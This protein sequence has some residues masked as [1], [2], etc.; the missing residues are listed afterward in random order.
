MR[1]CK[2]I[3]RLFRTWIFVPLVIV[4]FQ[5]V[6]LS[7]TVRTFFVAPTTKMV[8]TFGAAAVKGG[9]VSGYRGIEV[10]A[11][12]FQKFKSIAPPN[13]LK[14]YQNL[15]SGNALRQHL[16]KVMKISGG[17]VDVDIILLDD[18]T[19][20]G[21]NSGIFVAY[22]YG[23]KKISWPAASVGPEAGGRYRGLVRLSEESCKVF[24]SGTGTWLSWE[25]V[26]LHEMNHTQYVGQKT[27]WGR[28][29]ITYGASGS[30]WVSEF[31]GDQALAFEEGI[32]TF[33]GHVHNNPAGINNEKK[34]FS[35]TDY[36]YVLESWSVLASSLYRIPHK[37]VQ[38]T[39]PHAPPTPGGLYYHRYYKWKDVPGFYILFSESTSTAFHTFFWNYVNNDKNQAYDMIVKSASAMYKDHKK[40]Y[41]TYAVN[42]L[43]LQMEEY[44]ATAKGI[45]AKSA[46]TLTS[47]M[48]PFALLDILTHFG[49]SE[50][51]YK[52]GY[53]ANLPDKNPRAYKEYWRHRD[54]VKNLVNADLTANP[55]RIEQAISKAHKYFQAANTIL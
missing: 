32:G 52:R 53:E 10:N 38:K 34:F 17:K 4:A 21:S 23:G 18:Q 31:L 51:E 29:H 11:N 43:A 41:L 55:I 40:R 48:F 19:G 20:L 44:A 26:V 33:F 28:I 42:R 3:S 27:K 2:Q 35:R 25:S 1:K 50:A 46:G 12:N 8:N 37:Q 54:K 36:R 15:Q 45:A 24:T 5:Q 13:M 9:Y 7:Q 47:S 22:T 14:T 16:D 6:L 39:P 49:M 30:H